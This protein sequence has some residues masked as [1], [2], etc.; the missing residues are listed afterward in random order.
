MMYESK[1]QMYRD[2]RRAKLMGV[3]A[4]AAD[5][6]DLNVTFVRILFFLATGVT[7][8]WPGLFLYFFLGFA[9][10]P[11]PRDLY[12][13]RDE[14]ALWRRARTQPDYSAADLRR[15]FRDLEKRTSEMENEVT[16]K[17]FKLDRE[18]RD[19]EKNA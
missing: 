10:K 2:P 6:F 19:L 7:G 3:C 8:V 13:D 16:S 5:Y 15:R 18:L 11:K 14:E 17:R 12:K 4:G 9:L 1:T